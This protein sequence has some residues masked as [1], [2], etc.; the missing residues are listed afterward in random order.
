MF[1]D[2][3]YGNYCSEYNNNVN[4]MKKYKYRQQFADKPIEVYLGN[5]FYPINGYLRGIYSPSDSELAVYNMLI[6]RINETAQGTKSA[7]LKVVIQPTNTRKENIFVLFDSVFEDAADMEF[8]YEE[9]DM[10]A[11]SLY[12]WFHMRFIEYPGVYKTTELSNWVRNFIIAFGKASHNNTLY[13]LQSHIDNWCKKLE[14]ET[15]K[16]AVPYEVYKMGKQKDISGYTL[17]AVLI[18]DILFSECLYRL[19]KQEL[20]DSQVVLDALAVADF[21]RNKNKSLASEI[22]TRFSK[23]NMAMRLLRPKQGG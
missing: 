6:D 12:R 11:K 8:E 19:T 10:C 2:N 23:P 22:R 21:V 9:V 15:V 5:M 4:L 17:E 20:P 7:D 3:I 18:S 1:Q 14:T 16:Y 13:N